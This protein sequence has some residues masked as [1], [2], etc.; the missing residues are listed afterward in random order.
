MQLPPAKLGSLHP[1]QIEVGCFLGD[2]KHN[3]LEISLR[4]AA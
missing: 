4:A 1:V 2:E 3:F